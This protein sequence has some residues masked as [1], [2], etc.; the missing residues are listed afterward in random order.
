VF[1]GKPFSRAAKAGVNLVENEQRTKFIAQVSQQRQE[2]RRRDVDAAAR[3]D[4][5]NENRADLFAAEKLADA[6]FDGFQF[7]VGG[8]VTNL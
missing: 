8:K 2:F 1:A 7:F 4:R 6:G 3:L 5:L